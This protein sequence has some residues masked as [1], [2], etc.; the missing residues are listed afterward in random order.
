VRPSLLD[1]VA[2]AWV[3]VGFLALN[4]QRGGEVSI[5]ENVGFT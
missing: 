3:G 1:L 2:L 5:G 4:I